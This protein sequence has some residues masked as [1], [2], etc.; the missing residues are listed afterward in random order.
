[1]HVRYSEVPL[2]GCAATKED[3]LVI[4]GRLSSFIGQRFRVERQRFHFKLLPVSLLFPQYSV[5]VIS[6]KQNRFLLRQRKAS[7]VSQGFCE[8]R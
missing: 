8:L 5:A 3:A 1:V 6:D 7:G 2:T 4:V